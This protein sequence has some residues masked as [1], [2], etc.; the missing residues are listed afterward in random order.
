M[1]ANELRL[2]ERIMIWKN[3]SPDQSSE[4]GD[5]ALI[6]EHYGLEARFQIIRS[7]ASG[8]PYVRGHS[9]KRAGGGKTFAVRT[10]SKE[11]TDRLNNAILHEAAAKGIR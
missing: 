1:T 5:G 10:Q 8:L 7:R 3:P 2:P 9:F 11:H 4:L 6:L